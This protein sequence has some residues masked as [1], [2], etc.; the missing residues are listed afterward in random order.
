VIDV[1]ADLQTKNHASANQAGEILLMCGD[2]WMSQSK[3]L[4]FEALSKQ[5]ALRSLLTKGI[6]ADF[7]IAKI[8][9]KAD[10]IWI[11]VDGAS[12]D[13]RH[14]LELHAMG[15]VNGEYFTQFLNL[16]EKEHLTGKE[17]ASWISEQFGYYCKLQRQLKI[18][19]TP[20]YAITGIVF[21]TTSENTGKYNGVAACLE[22]LRQSL[23]QT[24]FKK[25]CDALQVK[26]KRESSP[27]S[28]LVVIMWLSCVWQNSEREWLIC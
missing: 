23:H 14:F 22:E 18:R 8:L 26:I 4:P 3:H 15:T 2:F 28:N 27:R 16:M 17:I 11:G 12:E 6:G 13:D 1:L 21:D 5:S 24:H 19:E 9:S 7:E 25:K 20:V 10:E